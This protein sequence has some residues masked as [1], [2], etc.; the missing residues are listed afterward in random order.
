M[1]NGQVIFVTIISTLYLTFAARE[2]FFYLRLLRFSPDHPWAALRMMATLQ[3]KR[4]MIVYA[5]MLLLATLASI[6]WPIPRFIDLF[7]EPLCIGCLKN[8]V[9]EKGDICKECDSWTRRVEVE[10]ASQ[11]DHKEEE[12]R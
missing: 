11:N 5:A 8:R 10:W 9:K 7:S 1:T 2:F 4:G 3:P 12:E 6:L